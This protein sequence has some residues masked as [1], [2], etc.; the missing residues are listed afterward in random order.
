MQPNDMKTEVRSHL[1]EKFATVI[2]RAIAHGDRTNA[3]CEF[4]NV[5]ITDI[6]RLVE[7]K[8]SQFELHHD[9]HKDKL[10][11]EIVKNGHVMFFDCFADTDEV[12]GLAE[13]SCKLLAETD[14]N[15][16]YDWCYLYGRIYYMRLENGNS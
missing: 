15:Y 9:L 11:S 1:K 3:G 10:D 5:D 8:F 13:R 6:I 12:K 14:P 2:A 16:Q 4:D 7:Q